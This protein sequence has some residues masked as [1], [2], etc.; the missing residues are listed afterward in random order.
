MSTSRAGG[1]VLPVS[2]LPGPYGI[3]SLGAQAR[4]FV[5]FLRDA[6]QSY[7]QV[8][9]LVPT[10]FGDS[11]YQ[12]SSSFAGNPYF[13]DL[14]Q[15]CEDGLLT[16]EECDACDFGADID[17]VDYSLLYKN[18]LRLLRLAFARGQTRLKSELAAFRRAE[19]HWLPDYAL[20]MAV[21][22]KF[23]MAAL[24]EW[25]DKA[26]RAR[27]PA[28]LKAYAG[29][30]AGDAAF[31]EFIQYIFFT[32]WRALRTYANAQGVRI[33]GDLPIYVSRDSAE[34][35]S[36]P[37]L[38][39]LD[40]DGAPRVVAGV[41]PDYYSETGQLWGNPIYDWPHHEK[42]GFAWWLS[43]LG[44]MAALF[45]VVRID[46]FRGFCN[47]WEVPAG[48]TTALKGRFRRGPGMN[49]VKAVRA[50]YPD[51]P[52]I[53]EDL[54]DLD[55][56]V[57]AF[58][59]KTGF[60]GMNV[61]VYAFDPNGDS[62]YLPHNTPANQVCYTSTHDSPTFLDWLTGEASPEERA[63]ATDY[64]RLHDSE[65]LSWGALCS[66][67]GSP[68]RLAMAPLQDVLGLG[69]DARINI[70]ATLGGENWRWR[71]R[72][73]A[74]NDGVAGRLRHLTGTYRRLP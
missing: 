14:P 34:V 48:E 68:G 8:L 64:L 61:L 26:I 70:P 21:K 13:I 33:I 25:P 52:V 2:S 67:W 32:Q 11:P 69:A 30:L 73:E 41:P 5:D 45:D 65:G 47:Y 35:W 37:E 58:F 18:R 55:D 50:A 40:K 59:R 16:R 24:D 6:G 49:F 39:L 71:V 57:R 31:H 12:S 42:T 56:K 20:F 38:F 44:H 28:A 36:R 51:L 23:G 22:A 10:G 27:K 9:P 62:P 46:H 17:R 66:V 3:G 72:S 1:I 43:R 29:E 15:L 53:A 60:P 74:L 54:G 4:L 19:A 7:W 63:F